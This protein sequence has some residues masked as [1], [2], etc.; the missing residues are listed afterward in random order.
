MLSRAPKYAVSHDR[1]D[2][3]ND[4]DTHYPKIGP[5]YSDDISVLR[6]LR[7]PTNNAGTTAAIPESPPP[8]GDQ[9]KV[10][11]D[12]TTEDRY[13][14]NNAAYNVE[15]VEQEDSYSG[16]SAD[17]SYNSSSLPNVRMSSDSRSKN[18][19]IDAYLENESKT[20]IDLEIELTL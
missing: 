7:T 18:E 1:D 12:D 15:E 13:D 4:D 20:I 11:M 14:P 9:Y 16:S 17:D 5:G 19:A 6:E 8:H 10:Y 2:D 3:D